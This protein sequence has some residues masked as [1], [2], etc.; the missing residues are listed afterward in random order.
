MPRTRKEISEEERKRRRF[1]FFEMI[2][3]IVVS[4]TVSVLTTLYLHSI[5]W[6]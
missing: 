3:K 6:V 2:V 4:A 1:E 5:G